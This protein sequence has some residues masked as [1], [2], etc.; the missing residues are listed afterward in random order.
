MQLGQ[1]LPEVLKGANG[2]EA[3]SYSMH[4]LVNRGEGQPIIRRRK[5]KAKEVMVK[6]GEVVLILGGQNSWSH[7]R[8]PYY[9]NA[10]NIHIIHN[11]C[12]HV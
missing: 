4:R 8:T 9:Y 10:Y 11:A 12:I 1:T 6:G 5:T 2:P 7:A 3:A